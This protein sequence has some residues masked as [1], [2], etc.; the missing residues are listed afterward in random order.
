MNVP[1]ALGRIAP[2]GGHRLSGHAGGLS[3]RARVCRSAG[4]IALSSLLLS[5]VVPVAGAAPDAG[6]SSGQGEAPA[7]VQILDLTTAG[8]QATEVAQSGLDDVQASPGQ[9]SGSADAAEALSRAPVDDPDAVRK[10]FGEVS[11][12]VVA[13][14]AAEPSLR[15]GLNIFECSMA[16]GYQKWV[17]KTET[18]ENPYMGSQM[19]ACGTKATWDG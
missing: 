3:A 6:D 17:Q 18:I 14:L 15:E 8:G 4:L 19:L 9:G 13:L 1:R 11:R 7:P 12:S 2:R 10:A 5:S 16:Q